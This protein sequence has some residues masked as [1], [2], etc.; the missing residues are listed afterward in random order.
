MSYN[1]AYHLDQAIIKVIGVGGGG[2]N[3]VEHMISQALP[4]VEFISVN[5]DKQ[6]LVNYTSTHKV[7][8]GS[9]ITK[10]LGAGADP[11]VGKASA[12]ENK[13]QLI[14]LIQGADMVFITAGMGGGTG[15]GA[16]PFIAELA[17]RMGILTVGVVTKPFSFEGTRRTKLAQ[18]GIT[19]L[20]K[21]VDSLITI[22]NN[23][24]LETLDRNLSL[25]DAFIAANNVLNSAVK[26]ISNLITQ[27]GLINVDFADVR[28][29]MANRGIAMMGTASA[30]G[31]NRA[32][33]AAR[34]AISS[35]LLE[36]IDLSKAK[37][38]LV[39][40]TA[41]T[42]MSI[43]EFEVVGS[44]ISEYMSDD[45]TVI[46]G[47]VVDMEMTD[48][49]SVT[50][51]VTSNKTTDEDDQ[52]LISAANSSSLQN[53]NTLKKPAKCLLTESVKSGHDEGTKSKNYDNLNEV[54]YLDIPAFLRRKV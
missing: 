38:V 2:C 20:S 31:A 32:E 27:P 36:N 25:L 6:A 12:Q 17:R 37:G 39:N 1:E 45:A 9:E 24:L 52:S 28:T 14:E 49:F 15:T 44:I 22:P 53:Q 18:Y 5:T 51:V 13:A 29:V 43:G 54:E 42:D 16:A 35:P 10:G 48:E 47:T 40:I 26:G 4:G 46:V 34:A 30:T 23:R 21:H 19:E 11:M 3:A 41:G 33:A 50:V 7:Q 8:I